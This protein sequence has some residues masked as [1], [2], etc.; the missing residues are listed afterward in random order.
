MF[1]KMVTMILSIQAY[2]DIDSYYY[3]YYFVIMVMLNER[4]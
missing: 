1:L 4:K 2:T 3:G